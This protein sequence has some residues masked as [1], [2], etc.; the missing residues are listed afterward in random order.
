MAPVTVPAK[1]GMEPKSKGPQTL[2]WNRS[3]SRHHVCGG[4]GA[5]D[6]SEAEVPVGTDP[7]IPADPHQKGSVRKSPFTEG[8]VIGMLQ[9]SAV[10]AGSGSS[11]DPRSATVGRALQRSIALSS[12][13][14]SGDG[15]LPEQ[16]A[17]STHV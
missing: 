12:W 13:M 16:G 14:P 11:P 10:G 6:R 8:Q 3:I 9:E 15:L 5:V 1:S 17:G 2:Y 7:V 4:G